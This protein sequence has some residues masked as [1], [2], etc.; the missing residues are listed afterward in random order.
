MDKIA[1]SRSKNKIKGNIP[2]LYLKP[3]KK[4]SLELKPSKIPKKKLKFNES[5]RRF[6]NDIT[7]SI[8]NNAQYINSHHSFHQKS[9]SVS[10]K[11]NM[12]GTKQGQT[13]DNNSSLKKANS[14]GR[15]NANKN[16]EKTFSGDNLYHKKKINESIDNKQ[17][18]NYAPS[19]PKLKQSNTNI[20][21]SNIENEKDKDKIPS[22]KNRDKLI[23]ISEYRIEPVIDSNNNKNENK[24]SLN[25]NKDLINRLKNQSCSLKS[26]ITNKNQNNNSKNKTINHIFDA[27]EFLAINKH[28]TKEQLIRR[29]NILSKH[30]TFELGQKK[31]INGDKNKF[32]KNA[33]VHKDIH[34]NSNNFS[35]NK[36]KKPIDIL[37][38][39]KNLKTFHP[40]K[41]NN[42]SIKKNKENKENI[43]NNINENEALSNDKIKN[44]EKKEKILEEKEKEINHIEN[45]EIDKEQNENKNKDKKEEINKQE[46]INEDKDIQI[47]NENTN[48]LDESAK[49]KKDS[50][51]DSELTHIEHNQD[52]S[53]TK[54]YTTELNISQEK[55]I[56]FD[57]VNINNVQIPKEYLN[58]IY[59]N[60]L[61][62][63]RLDNRCP[64]QIWFHR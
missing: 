13:L 55:V 16:V 63:S 5:N 60:L 62:F 21:K 2:Q 42:K 10:N 61:V 26:S 19:G 52:K 25:N 31:N 37:F 44:D 47:K 12:P 41:Q 57:T 36:N 24:N 46:N 58:T 7:N 23:R 4:E 22:P 34:N 11:A 56:Y 14:N 59:Y 45:K 18:N 50:E 3:S 15:N 33:H 6:G 54:N 64:S 9:S 8:K 29:M 28:L 40:N 1:K 43:D 38:K 30:D 53:S 32:N 48:N 49:S 20:N 35:K 17:Q 51:K 27:K 39:I